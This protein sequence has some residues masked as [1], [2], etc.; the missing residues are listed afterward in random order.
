MALYAH[1]E[2]GRA[3]NVIEAASQAEYEARFT[4]EARAGWSVVTVPNGTQDNAV[5]NGN[6]TYANPTTASPQAVPRALTRLQFVRLCK[7]AGG[8][9]GQMLVAAEADDNLAE[10]W[11]ML[12]L[13]EDVSRDDP[14][15][16]AGLGALEALGYLPE[17]AAGVIGAW[18]LG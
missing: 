17:G 13:A 11:I 12:R 5:S 8:M 4:A 18:P 9:T 1:I 15:T 2:T 6:G 3:L 10:M 14:D 7:S 16:A